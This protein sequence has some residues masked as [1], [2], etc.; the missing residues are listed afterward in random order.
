[1]ANNK[2][3]YSDKFI[4]TGGTS[5]QYLMADGTI[6]TTGGQG[7]T[8]SQGP[9][10]SNGSNGSQGPSGTN[11]SNGSQGPAGSNG[12]NGSQGPS[13]AQGP[14]GSSGAGAIDGSGTAN[15]VPKFS[16]SDTIT[17]SVIY[18]N[19]GVGINTTDNQHIGLSDFA[20]KA[21]NST[22]Q[23]MLIDEDAGAGAGPK[24]NIVRDSSSPAA[25]DNV[26]VINFIGN[27]SDGDSVVYSKILS[28]IEAPDTNGTGKL[29]FFTTKNGVLQEPLHMMGNEI[30]ME[31]YI[32]IDS[33][34]E[35]TINGTTVFTED[36]ELRATNLISRAS[37]GAGK[38]RGDIVS[39]GTYSSSN[40][41]VSAGDVVV[42]VSGV[43]ATWA[44]AQ[45][46]D[47][48]YIKGLLGIA[49]NNSG[50]AEVLIKGYYKFS[51]TSNTP[52]ATYYVSP[53]TA[54]DYQTV[55]PSSSGDYAR[56]FAY[57]VSSSEIFVNPSGTWIEIA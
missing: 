5:S 50:T 43:G 14:A 34:S 18:E 45:A 30:H 44:K 37:L 48:N 56:I 19:V 7:T 17:D 21:V 10:G 25:S 23:L 42:L 27:D 4:K 41:T 13:G 29:S 22:S 32:E 53:S 52:G 3:Y 2:I 28:N 46:D 36:V 54:G 12:S 40:G 9:A 47:N 16:D 11:G 24:M 55:I 38:A 20:I 49:I 33:S 35:L 15:Y 51:T 26:G 1:M 6:S 31:G 57:G 8:G 39:F